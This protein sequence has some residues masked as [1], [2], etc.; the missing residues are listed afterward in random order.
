MDASLCLGKSSSRNLA[1]RNPLAQATAGADT[2]NGRSSHSPVKSLLWLPSPSEWEPKS[3]S[4]R[5]NGNARVVESVHQLLVEIRWNAKLLKLK[6]L[7]NEGKR[8]MGHWR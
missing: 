1:G 7:G 6:E 4:K 3:W 8:N 5:Q 2:K